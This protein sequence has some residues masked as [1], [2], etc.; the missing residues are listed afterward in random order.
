M[1]VYDKTESFLKL[2]SNKLRE[3]MLPTAKLPKLAE[4]SGGDKEMS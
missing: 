4:P 3:T 1:N 2:T